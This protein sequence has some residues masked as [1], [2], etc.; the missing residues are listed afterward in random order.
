MEFLGEF[1]ASFLL[2]FVLFLV[3]G[4]IAFVIRVILSKRKE[5]GYRGYLSE[6]FTSLS[7]D[8][9]MLM[10]KSQSK[11]AKLDISLVIDEQNNQAIILRNVSGKQI[12]H[13]AYP[14]ADITSLN[15]HNKMIS[16]GFAPKTWSYEES[17]ELV[18]KDDIHCFFYL[19]NI[20]NR[21][22]TDKGADVVREMINPWY[23]KLVAYL[24]EQSPEV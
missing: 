4:V 19:E 1:G 8:I 23:K 24:P 10:A 18:F 2:Y 5:K 7:A 20:S 17:L 6:H 15:R 3:I 11:K 14:V 22:G 16:R 21:D 12:E 9:P 13:N